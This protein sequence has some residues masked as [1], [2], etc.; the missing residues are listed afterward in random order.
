MPSES[1]PDVKFEIGHVL[2]IDIVGY[3][4]LLINEQSEQVQ[5]LREIV[6]GAE[7]FR[8][9][10]AEGKLVRLPTGDGGALVFQTTPEA[11][12]SCALEIS[13][14]L[15]K[16]PE[17]RVR[18][19]I[20]SG[21]VNAVTDLNEQSNIA[22]AGI[23]IA[24][25][26][27]DCGD[28]GHILLSKHVAED[29][30]HYPRWQPYL[31]DLGEWEVKHGVRVSVVNLYGNDAG[32]AALPTRLAAQKRSSATAKQSAG[33]RTLLVAAIILIGLGVPTIIFTPAIK[34][35]R[36]PISGDKAAQSSIPGKS[37][38]VL[39]FV[40]LSADKNDEYL[41]DG[42]TEELLNVLTKVK[43]LRVPGRSASFAFKGKTED[44]I[45]RKVGDQ[46]HVNAVLEGSVRK[47]GDK[48]RV[49]AQ[50][51][52]VA[53]GFHLWSETYDGDMKDILAMQSDVAQRVVK[54]LQV[55]LG[56]DESRALTKR[57]TENAEAYR[58]YLLGRY[59]FA[60]FTRAGW[61]NA[62]QYFEQALQ[63]DPNYTLAY[64][65]LADTYGWAGGQTLPGNEAWAKEMEL[66]QKALALDPNLAEAHL[67]MATALF[68]VLNPRASE[69]ELDRAVELD[70][71]QVLIYD[72]YGWTFSEMGRFDEAIAAEKKG[73]E[74]DP[75]NIFLNSD[76]GFF[77]NW[78]RRYD[79]G[80]TQLRKTLELDANNPLAHHALG[81]SLHWKGKTVDAL[82]EF[83]KAA[84]L[85]DLPWY[86]GSLGYA[87][88]ASGDRAKAEQILRD[89]DELA[90]K[91]YV[92]PAARASVYLGLG[93]KAKAL[94]WIEKAYEDRDPLLWWNADRLYD[95]VRNEPRFQALMQ[96]VDR[97]KAGAKP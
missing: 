25:R 22:G 3:S 63:V 77:Y 45:F 94:D 33:F 40:N 83:Q 59:H 15:K 56:V 82:A 73:L 5:T 58:L 66:A 14:E 31:H 65:G 7:Q 85:D 21:P 90:K 27:M 29:L 12:V 49:T 10:D 74:L 75:L 19:G 6:R 81:W 50:L 84:A 28:A 62:I 51:I 71:N 35:L 2:F 80:I 44:G 97:M 8:L 78:A 47:A 60:K 38:A 9:A 46:L 32:N 96:E 4:K 23:N 89:L 41:S 1:S 93:E 13:K 55:Q 30:E 87:Y 24:Q 67:S 11:P 79:D 48:L 57:P 54:A 26:V 61:T 20:H 69:K 16:H 68:S 95:S 18:M 70:P 43:G 37:I 53:D 88:A 64:C 92:S 91:Q 52:N 72:Q 42:M 39:P 86:K 17:L 36:S 76:L 34:S